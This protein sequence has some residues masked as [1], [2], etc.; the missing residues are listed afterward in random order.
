MRQPGSPPRSCWAGQDQK[1]RVRGGE[2]GRGWGVTEG[3]QRFFVSVS[4]VVIE[5]PPMQI[6][7]KTK[8]PMNTV[9]GRR[10]TKR[11]HFSSPSE[12]L[13]S[14]NPAHVQSIIAARGSRLSLHLVCE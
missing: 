5:I 3:V 13:F 2:Q 7:A 1:G 9:A 6:A 10:A 12:S 11:P 8:L 4:L 14:K